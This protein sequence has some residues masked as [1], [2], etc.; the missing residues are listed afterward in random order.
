MVAG[1]EEKWLQSSWPMG[2]PR[3]LESTQRHQ[4]SAS[5]SKPSLSRCFASGDQ[6]QMNQVVIIDDLEVRN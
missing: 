3:L 6:A 4:S 1:E 2:R 5:C